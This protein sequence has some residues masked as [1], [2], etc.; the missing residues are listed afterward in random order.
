MPTHEPKLDPIDIMLIG[1]VAAF[2]D[3]LSF[4]PVIGSLGMGLIRFIFYLKGL[5]TAAINMFFGVG[6]LAE[7][8]PV[9][10]ILPTCIAYVVVAAMV[11]RM[12]AAATPA[13]PDESAAEETA[14][15]QEEPGEA[16]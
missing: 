5:N 4:I 15:E 10:S 13:Q 6:A 11:D 8:I 14:S 12:E 7:A 3:V 16:A 9:V 1:S 2:F